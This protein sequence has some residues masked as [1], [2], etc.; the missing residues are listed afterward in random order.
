[1]LKALQDRIVAEKVNRCRDSVKAAVFIE[2]D[3]M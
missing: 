1:M 2:A 3:F